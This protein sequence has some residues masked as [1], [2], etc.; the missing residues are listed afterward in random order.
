MKLQN[1]DIRHSKYY[2]RLFKW[3]L[4][5]AAETEDSLLRNKTRRKTLLWRG[6]EIYK[7]K[8]TTNLGSNK[9][10]QKTWQKKKNRYILNFTGS[11]AHDRKWQCDK[12]FPLKCSA[13]LCA[14][15]LAEIPDCTPH[16]VERI[17]NEQ[18]PRSLEE[19]EILNILVSCNTLTKMLVILKPL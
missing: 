3:H 2:M 8:C 1:H 12:L 9:Q 7:S 10:N 4:Y 18:C 11:L 14:L 15:T 6:A 16:S 17:M 13:I 5:T 19:R